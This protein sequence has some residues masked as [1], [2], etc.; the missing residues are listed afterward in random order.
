MVP[1]SDRSAC[2]QSRRTRRQ[3][4]TSGLVMDMTGQYEIILKIGLKQIAMTFSLFL[5]CALS[6]YLVAQ[7]PCRV[8]IVK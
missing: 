6:R 3:I 2:L 8:I 7:Q 4:P 1:G 5:K